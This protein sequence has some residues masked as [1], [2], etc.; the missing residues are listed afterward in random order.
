MCKNSCKLFCNFFKISNFID[1]S[2]LILIFC[3]SMSIFFSYGFVN[4][5]TKN[6]N[7]SHI[8][9]NHI[10]SINKSIQK[11]YYTFGCYPT[12]IKSM[13][14]KKLFNQKNGNS[15]NENNIIKTNKLNNL[16]IN[17]TA[18]KIPYI[19]LGFIAKGSV[20]IL[21][22]KSNHFVYEINGLDN[23]LKNSLFNLCDEK[24]IKNKNIFNK[25]PKNHNPF[26]KNN[27][28]RSDKNNNFW[29]IIA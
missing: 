26:Y 2:K 23:N 9:L 24:Y 17:A 15:C 25:F 16:Y 10:E 6:K 14:N 3:F 5:D 8:L 21:K 13:R 28:C 11:Q 18:S 4:I 27:P 7:L 12:S 1:I 20:G 29:I 19:D 22:N